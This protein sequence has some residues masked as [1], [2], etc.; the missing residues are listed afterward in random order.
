MTHQPRQWTY[1]ETERPDAVCYD[2]G[3]PYG[4][5]PVELVIAHEQWELINPSE[6]RG[7]GLLCH[8]CMIDRLIE[9]G[10]FIVDVLFMGIGTL[11]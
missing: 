9:K 4:D 1:T 3:L 10:I 7:G 5:F 11:D 8:N 2:C 6:H